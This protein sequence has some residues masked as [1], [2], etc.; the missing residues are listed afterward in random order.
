MK[1]SKGGP[2]L[3]LESVNLS[4]EGNRVLRDINL[5]IL[6]IQGF[7]KN[8]GQVVTLLGRSGVGKTQ[9]FKIISGLMKPTSGNVLIGLEQKPVAP[10]IVG[11]VQQN[12]PLFKHRTLM[13]N[14]QLVSKDKER[15]DYYLNEFDI[16]D[17]RNAYPSQLSGGQRQR[18]A[19][20]Q[21][22]LCSEHFILLDEPFSG[23][24]PVATDKLCYNIDKVVHL[25]SQ[26]TVIISTHILSPALAISDEV[27]MLGYEYQME[28]TDLTGNPELVKVPGAI[29]KHKYDLAA[30]G[31]AW[32]PDIRKDHRFQELTEEIRDL[33]KTL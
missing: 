32:N 15:I 18:S 10:G 27:W 33:F 14:L 17:R 30:E 20:I 31:L 9:L 22:L 19:I 28:P 26:N 2:L 16:W 3:T 23:L 8:L 13:Q 4:Y 21:Q 1:Y 6:D 24:D 12:Y 29:L 11:V 25:D 7:D 5:Q